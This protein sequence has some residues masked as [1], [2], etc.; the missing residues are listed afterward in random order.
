MRVWMVSKVSSV[1]VRKFWQ[2]EYLKEFLYQILSMLL[3]VL[4]YKWE[5][6]VAGVLEW[7]EFDYFRCIHWEDIYELTPSLVLAGVC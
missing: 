5:V 2:L 3:F 7:S 4:Y 6:I 1:L